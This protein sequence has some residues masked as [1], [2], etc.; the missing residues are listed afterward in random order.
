M[1]T[2]STLKRFAALPY[3]SRSLTADGCTGKVEV[4]LRLSQ[5]QR[6]DELTCGGGVY[7]FS[8]VHMQKAPCVC[9]ECRVFRFVSQARQRNSAW[10]R[11]VGTCA[12]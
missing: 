6:V 9:A 8:A 10:G 4:L 3:N 11:A 5:L 12:E 7:E 2:N 1:T